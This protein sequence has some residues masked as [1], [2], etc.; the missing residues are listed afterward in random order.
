MISVDAEP[1][2][3]RLWNDLYVI[4]E[5]CGGKIRISTPF[6]VQ[7]TDESISN[8]CVQAGD[9]CIAIPNDSLYNRESNKISNDAVINVLR[10]MRNDI[11]SI[12]N[13]IHLPLVREG[14]ISFFFY[15]RSL[16]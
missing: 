15:T 14:T 16:L 8:Y 9:I 6:D 12:K 3:C 2:G 5:S 13:V 7:K 4:T 10:D 11:G 1:W